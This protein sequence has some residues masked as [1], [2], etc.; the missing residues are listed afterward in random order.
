MPSSTSNNG[1]R[2]D[3]PLRT[4]FFDDH[5]VK[6]ATGVERVVHPATKSPDNPVLTADMP[7]EDQ[8]VLLG[9]TVRKEESGL[10]MWYQAQILGQRREPGSGTV[11]LYA[12]SDDGVH[13]TRPNLGQWEF[14][15]STVNNMYANMGAR[16]GGFTGPAG[17]RWD[18]NQ[19]VMYTPHLG[20]GQR[21]TM[22]AR[23]YGRGPYPYEGSS[24]AFS[25]D[26]IEWTDGP[27]EP[28]IPGY[29]DVNWF[30]YDDIAN[31][32][33]GTLKTRLKVG[34]WGRRSVVYT[35]GEDLDTWDLPRP[36][37]VHDAID[38]A[39]TDG[40]PDRYTQFYGMPMVRYGSVVIGLLEVFRC[41]DGPRSTDG[42]IHV[43]LATTRDGYRWERPDRTHIIP[44]GDEGDWDWGLVQTGNSLVV[45]GDVVRVY[46]TGSRYRHGD[47]GK[48]KPAD[49]SSDEYETWQAIGM[50]TWPRDRIVG[51]RSGTSG[52]EIV[53][54]Q[55]VTGNELHFNADASSGSLVV[56][57][58][59]DQGLPVP[60]FEYA[61]ATALS[62]DSLDHVVGWRSNPS[63]A[64]LTDKKVLVRL[65]L[66]RAEIF[67][68]W[69][70]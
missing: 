70:E 49:R 6:S 29:G 66:D 31:R 45:D 68:M 67:S 69:W 28:I 7:W 60:G 14:H 10:R 16:R 50:A 62:F 30:M 19:T 47:K 36:A 48:R 32:F 4:L 3:V 55:T 5:N 8:R 25:R 21:Y 18:H 58:A 20:E 26:G 51:L 64:N 35:V 43:E 42:F 53:V 59:D 38:D 33:R 54:E 44:S 9:G 27:D 34:D 56:E 63:L 12:E 2:F 46:F 13:W 37:F 65:R 17:G 23:T 39:W 41:Y 40:H 11:N 57:L 24:A 61:S 22:L 52:G 15:G 1:D